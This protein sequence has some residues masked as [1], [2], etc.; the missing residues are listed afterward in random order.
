MS[1]ELALNTYI[2]LGNA[3]NYVINGPRFDYKVELNAPAEAVISLY[4]TLEPLKP[5]EVLSAIA[6]LP[7]MEKVLLDRCCR[8]CLRTLQDDELAAKL[9]LSRDVVEVV[10]EELSLETTHA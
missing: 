5:G 6:G 2:L 4:R 8:Y 7:D 3:L 1:S 9:G 10:L